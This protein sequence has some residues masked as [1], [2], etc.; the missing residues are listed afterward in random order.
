MSGNTLTSLQILCVNRIERA[1]LLLW[2]F[3]HFSHGQLLNPREQTW[4]THSSEVNSFSFI[5]IPGYFIELRIY[6]VLSDN[7]KHLTLDCFSTTVGHPWQ[8]QKGVKLWI[9]KRQKSLLEWINKQ[10]LIF[11]QGMSKNC[12]VKVATLKLMTYLGAQEKLLL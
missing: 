2:R 3:I 11:L 8:K 5:Y 10:L 7:L 1:D 6:N 4:R 9:W 12:I